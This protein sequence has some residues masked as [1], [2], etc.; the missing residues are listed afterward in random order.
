MVCHLKRSLLQLLQPYIYESSPN[1]CRIGNGDPNKVSK[2]EGMRGGK[3][4][5]SPFEL[6]QHKQLTTVIIYELLL[7]TLAMF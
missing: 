3:Q 1:T 6:L 2:E 7:F 4:L 5:V